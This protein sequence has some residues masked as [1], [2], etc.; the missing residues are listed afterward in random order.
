MSRIM[1]E[2]FVPLDPAQEDF[3][4]LELTPGV[5]V[6]WKRGHDYAQVP[7]VG[8]ICKVCRVLSPMTN[9][10]FVSAPTAPV[11]NNDFTILFRTPDGVLV[12]YAYDS[13][14]FEEV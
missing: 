13:R 14:Y 10:Y 9:S 1:D 6:R 12:E 8:E 2:G 4:P 5:E 3:V 7:A 11:V